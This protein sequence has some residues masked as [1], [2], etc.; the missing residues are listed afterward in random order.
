MDQTTGIEDFYAYRSSLYDCFIRLVGHERKIK[1]F[2]RKRISLRSGFRVLDAGC[3]SGAIIRALSTVVAEQGTRN[4]RYYGFDLT[5]KMLDR[6]QAWAVDHQ[7]QDIIL[8]RADV[9]QLPR[10]LPEEWHAFDIILSS[11]MLEYVPRAQIA[12]A[13]RRLRYASK[14]QAT[15]F[16]FI[17]RDGWFNRI[18]LRYFWK[19][20]L[21][22][23]EQLVQLL[24]TSGWRLVSIQAFASWGYVIEATN[25]L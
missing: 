16:L 5:T 23:Q 6:F 4:V 2:L 9:C 7:R 17:S 20:E 25:D 12:E 19:A 21:Y 3:G 22:T 14:P 11:G 8:C 13:L 15:F 18:I 1:L 10:G 24:K